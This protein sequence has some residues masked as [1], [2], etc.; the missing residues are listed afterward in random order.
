MISIN[1]EEKELTEELT[2]S[3]GKRTESEQEQPES[4]EGSPVTEQKEQKFGRLTKEE[5]K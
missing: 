2:E 3:E 5:I 1:L 4:K